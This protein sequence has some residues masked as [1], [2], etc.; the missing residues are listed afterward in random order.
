MCP[1][2]SVLTVNSRARVSAY[3]GFLRAVMI[4]DRVSSGLQMAVAI[5]CGLSLNVRSRCGVSGQSRA[6]L[7]KGP[8]WQVVTGVEAVS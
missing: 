2:L 4:F 8:K 5:C 3:Q 7:T 1:T 6:P